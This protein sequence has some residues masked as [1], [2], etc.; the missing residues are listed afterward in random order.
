MSIPEMISNLM[1]KIQKEKTIRLSVVEKEREIIN[2]YFSQ[3]RTASEEIDYLKELLL[4]EQREQESWKHEALK[5][6]KA[7]GS[8]KKEI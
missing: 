8:L 3:N 2:K 1:L 6:E 7:N 4:E 5:F